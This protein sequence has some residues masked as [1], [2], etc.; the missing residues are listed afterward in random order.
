[1]VPRNRLL[2]Y[3]L[4]LGVFSVINTEMGVIGILPLLAD[5][6]D[7][8]V[9]KTALLV[10]VFA[11]V[12][13]FSGLFMPILLSGFNRK[14]IML[15]SLGIFVLGN[16]I[17]IFASSFNVVVTARAV[18]AFFQP[19]FVSLTLAIATSSSHSPEQARKSVS[20]VMMGVS[21]GMVLGVP[22]VSFIAN[23]FSTEIAM[24]FITLVNVLAF[25]GTML[26]VPSMPVQEKVS[27]GGQLSILKR[28]LTWLSIATIIFIAAAVNAPNSFISEYLGSV[29]Q[30]SGQTLSVMLLLFGI[31]SIFGNLLAGKLL[32]KNAMK[33]AIFFPIVL[34]VAFI[35]WFYTGEFIV[36]MVV[37]M[38]LFGILYSLAVNISQYWISSAAPEAPDFANGLFVSCTNW[39][40][41]LGT[42][43]G[44]LFLSG[45]GIRY[46]LWGG[47]LF[48]FLSLV[49]VL[50][51]NFI[52]NPAINSP[53]NN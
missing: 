35:L 39:G 9:T 47:L 36:P 10:S 28:P 53:N 46:I 26:F 4:A 21:A 18:M 20:T 11:L 30:I 38:V 17:T 44:G 7:I 23:S 13:A 3:I 49:S 32:S 22:I 37:M 8:T 5:H 2:I 34:G 42:A 14:K 50:L 52:Y 51:R 29:T 43:V 15:I 31:A 19:I 48:L 16:F 33:T 6:Y 12:V 25:L 41:S 27:Y 24:T 45:I 40:V 1:M